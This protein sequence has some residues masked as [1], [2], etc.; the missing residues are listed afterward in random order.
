VQKRSFK[1][2]K[3]RRRRCICC[4]AGPRANWPPGSSAVPR[5]IAAGRPALKLATVKLK[6]FSAEMATWRDLS[7]GADFPDAG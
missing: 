6:E 4:L 2:S 3:R 5:A 1:R 7:L